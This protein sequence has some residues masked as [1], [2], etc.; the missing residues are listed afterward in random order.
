[1]PIL[2]KLKKRKKTKYEHRDMP[3][4]PRK[5]ALAMF[6]YGLPEKKRKRLEEHKV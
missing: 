2:K 5:L 6:A 4:D 3:E 1:M